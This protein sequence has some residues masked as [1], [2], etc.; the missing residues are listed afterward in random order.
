MTIAAHFF[1][2]FLQFKNPLYTLV[3]T[4]FLYVTL[5]DSLYNSVKSTYKV[6]WTKD[7]I[8][9]RQ[10]GLDGGFAVAVL[11]GDGTHVHGIGHYDTFE[12]EFAAKFILQNHGRKR[13]WQ[14]VAS[15]LG[16]GYVGRHD[17][18]S[19]HRP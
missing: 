8:D 19:S 11:L 3:D 18:Q 17:R 5:F 12:A 7:Y 2:L 13:G 9:T 6:F 4:R 10:D 1:I 15:H 14:I 16:S